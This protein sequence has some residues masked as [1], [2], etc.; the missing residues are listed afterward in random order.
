MY[1]I[2]SESLHTDTTPPCT[3]GFDTGLIKEEE[4]ELDHD[5]EVDESPLHIV[6]N[7]NSAMSHHPYYQTESRSSEELILNSELNGGNDDDLS[8]SDSNSEGDNSIHCLNNKSDGNDG[9]T[10]SSI[11]FEIVNNDHIMLHK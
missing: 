11:H 1:E 7:E 9:S 10:D 8:H 3:T 5:D 6:N 4:A 2:G